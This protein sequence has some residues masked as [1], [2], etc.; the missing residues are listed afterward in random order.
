[1]EIRFIEEGTKMDIQVLSTKNT[2]L[3][4][5]SFLGT[6]L[7]FE[8]GSTFL[9]QCDELYVHANSLTS[10]CVLSISFFKGAE[11]AVFKAR[12]NGTPL[13]NGQYA[14]SLTAITPIEKHSR[15]KS[16][17]IEASFPVNIYNAD[18][19]QLISKET[20]FDVSNG[21]L[22]V[23]TNNRLPLIQ[24]EN[25]HVEFSLKPPQVFSMTARLVRSGDHN[26]TVSYR[27]DHAFVFD[28][29]EDNEKTSKLALALFE[30]KL[31]NI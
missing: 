26:Q 19:A 18:A 16:P 1:M 4:N 9:I 28:Y 15:R 24:G 29:P 31:K 27:F 7:Y 14:L 2:C 3:N 22:C 13:F 21:G 23:S 11:V 17:R 8:G 25:Y 10:E 20:T 30:Y 12:L 6:F 5:K